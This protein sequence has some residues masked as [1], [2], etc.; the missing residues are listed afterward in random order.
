MAVPKWATPAGNLGVVPALE[1]YQL[2][3]QASDASGG[4]LVYNRVS[5]R[6]PPGI[7]VVRTGVLQGVPISEAVPDTNQT[8]TF[9]I[10]VTNT[11]TGSVADRTFSLTITN[12][13]PPIIIPRNVNLGLFYDGSTVNIQLEAIEFVVEDNLVWS[14]KSGELPPGI[15]LSQDGLLSGFIRP[16]P[17]IGPG[18]DPDWDDTP[19]DLL[20]W[21]FL[22]GSVRKLFTFTIEVT[23]G[24]NTDASTYILDVYPRRSLIASTDS[25]TA[26]NSFVNINVLPKHFPII[27]TTQAD[28]VVERQGGYYAFQIEA[29]DLN[30]DILQ[31][32]MPA[33][34]TGAFDEH[35]N[36]NDLPYVNHIVDD[37][38]LYVGITSPTSTSKPALIPG[39]QVQVLYSS[40]LTTNEVTWYSASISNFTTVRLF[41]NSPVTGNVGD[42][43]TQQLSG[44]NATISNISST[45]GTITL[46]GNLVLANVGAFV[47]QGSANAVVT[48]TSV[49]T[50]SVQVI[51]LTG[52][53]SSTGGN[54][55]V[56]GVN[57]N[58]SPVSASYF[59]DIGCV[60]NNANTFTFNTVA[61][62]G[63]ANIA[64]ISTNSRPLTITSVGVNIGAVVDQTTAPAAVGYDEGKFDQG[65]LILPLTLLSGQTSVIDANSGW[66]TGFLPELTDNT[67]NYEFEISVFKR[68]EPIYATSRIFTLTVLGDLDNS[69]SWLTPSYLGSID[70]GKVSDLY[71]KAVS[72][73]GK[74]L[75]YELTPN[76]FKRLPQGLLL[77][78]NGLIS[79]RVSFQL[80]TLDQGLTTID[81]GSTTFDDT[82]S[83]S[84]TAYTYDGSVSA[85]REFTIR[86]NER[87]TSPY[88][89]LYLKAALSLEQRSQF[90]DIVQDPTVFPTELIYRIEDPYYGVTSDVKALFLAGINPSFL[91]E[92]AAAVETNHFNKRITFGQVKTA[93]VRSRA[94]D[95]AEIGTG[96]IIGTFEDEIGFAPSD[97]NSGYTADTNIPVGTQLTEE[98]IK[99]EVVYVEIND[100][101]TISNS[102][103]SFGPASTIDLTSQLVNPYLDENGNSYSIAYPNAFSNMQTKIVLQLG[104]ANKGALPDW[105]TSLQPN[106]TVLGFKRAVVLA[107]TI[108]GAGEAV[109][110]RFGQRR[111]NLTALDFTV[112]R[113]Q[114]DN[115]Y[116]DNYNIAE[117]EFIGGEETTY[118]RYP[119]ASLIFATIGTVDYAVRIPYE[120]I[121]NRSIADI[122]ALGGLDS[123]TNFANG[124]TIVFAQQ[125]FRTGISVGDTY[126]QGWTDVRTL[127]AKNTDVS[128]N[129]TSD[130]NLDP[131]PGL[132]WDSDPWDFSSYVPGYN[133]NLLNPTVDNRRIGI[134]RINIDNAGIVTL[135]FERTVSFYNRLFVRRGFTFGR[136]NIFYDPAVKPRNLIPNYSIIPEQV[137]IR[138]TIFDGNGTRFISN[139]DEYTTPQSGDKYIKFAKTGV[140]T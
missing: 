118:D 24:A 73:K 91:S 50:S 19:W 90:Q 81:G 72:S 119:P 123:I 6:L 53:F 27:L 67:T 15:S 121:N 4:T 66:I 126:N 82:Y 116:T 83:F 29:I 74:A 92:Y 70:N 101:N 44:A 140:F 111:F 31:Y 21:D 61:P 54:I 93:V 12:V 137:D 33:V 79:G 110:W 5:G 85:T 100:D 13:A 25:L 97:L 47:T 43:L 113:Y 3:L 117:E 68:D 88:E 22:V 20:G 26:D 52:T 17:V 37:G 11:T 106:G 75:Y 96:Q 107:Y 16:T 87:N 64:G 84:I 80:F 108:P 1:F 115:I 104:Y 99:Y 39:D 62:T 32:A 132:A 28:M 38:N 138:G 128:D 94:Y 10:R 56:N 35:V 63:I 40:P 8:Y 51:H 77:L 86:V 134:W 130:P 59:T 122:N 133:E 135:I 2:P 9:T 136:T 102:S 95:V 18:S 103:G 124:E 109:A 89:N 7:Q 114:L 78:S 57:A 41:G 58:A 139:R 129:D 30:G 46:V 48:A 36:N 125:E 14:L 120:S 23:D 60:Y 105:M 112:D 131:T 127:W 76:V 71:V 98:Q 69:V 65:I 34:S 45:F 49:Y 55:F 42:F